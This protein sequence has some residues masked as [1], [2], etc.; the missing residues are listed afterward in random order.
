MGQIHYPLSHLPERV[1]I[2]EVGPRDGLQNEDVIL[3]TEQKVRLINCLSD[4]GLKYIEVGSF[5]HPKVVPQMA[6]TA[7]V[8]A[9][10]DR[11]PGVVYSAIAPNAKGAERAIAAGVDAVQVFLSASESH[12]KSNVNM[13]IAESLAAAGEIARIVRGAGIT[14]EAVISV[15]FGC[16]FEGD[17]PIEQTLDLVER[18]VDLGAEQITL[19]DTTGM[20]N[21]RLVQEVFIAFR[22]RFP[23]VPVRFHPHSARGAGIANALAALQVGIDRLDASIGGIGGCPFAPGARGNIC[24]EDL[25]HM[26]HEMGIE[27]GVD[28]PNLVECSRLVEELL[29][30]QVPGQTLRSGICGHIPDGRPNPRFRASNS[31]IHVAG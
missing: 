27:T 23:T 11:R 18:L 12:N 10:I 17:V 16:P 5:V 6:D 1:S 13:R 26:L 24:S 19:G 31:A 20:G 4:T 22:E 2:R 21:P 8:F 25:V 7:E 9:R 14:F 29:G 15:V 3:S 28:L 30:R